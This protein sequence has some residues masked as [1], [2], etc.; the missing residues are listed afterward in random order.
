MFVRLKRW[1]HTNLV[2]SQK[3]QLL[4]VSSPQRLCLFLWTSSNM[5]PLFSSVTLMWFSLTCT[6][7]MILSPPLT[8]DY[9]CH[10]LVSGSCEYRPQHTKPLSELGVPRVQ[11]WLQ[12][13]WDLLGCQ[14]I[15]K[16][17]LCLCS[18]NQT[19]GSESPVYRVLNCLLVLSP[20]KPS[21]K[22]FA[23]VDEHK[24][25]T[26]HLSCIFFSRFLA[27]FKLTSLLMWF[28]V[29]GLCLLVAC[30]SCTVVEEGFRPFT[31]LS[32]ETIVWKCSD[33][34]KDPMSKLC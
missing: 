32:V 14:R 6:F 28:A 25:P 23:H 29:E 1:K 9:G 27:L 20:G 2:A 22:I 19:S 5:T 24:R 18:K 7:P 17:P 30:V 10:Q 12:A 34:S 16:T 13:E 21:F 8:C 15:F 11:L 3:L 33:T 31:W 4:L 26:V